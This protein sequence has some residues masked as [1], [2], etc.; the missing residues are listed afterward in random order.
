MLNIT[1]HQKIQVKTTIRY[2]LIP[3]GIA[4][5]RKA[6]T[7]AR[8]G[9]VA[10]LV[11]CWWECKMMQLLWKTVWIFLKKL[12]TELRMSQKSHFWVFIQRN[13]KQNLEKILALPCSLQHYSQQA[14]YMEQSKCPSADE[15][16]KKMWYLHTMEYYSALFK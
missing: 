10:N 11:H 4:I 16:I 3:V 13:L 5:F 12:K 15:W 8:I 2:H 7:L 9:E 6:K 14:R 1:G